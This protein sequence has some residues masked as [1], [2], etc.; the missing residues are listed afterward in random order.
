MD[1]GDKSDVTRKDEKENEDESRTGGELGILSIK[2]EIPCNSVPVDSGKREQ[3]R[4]VHYAGQHEESHDQTICLGLVVLKSEPDHRIE[5]GQ[6]TFDGECSH[7]EHR[8]RDAD[9]E[10]E[11]EDKDRVKGLAQ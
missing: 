11:Q 6:E 7:E 9:V 1:F 8:K 10:D 2:V 4:R 5:D 3:K